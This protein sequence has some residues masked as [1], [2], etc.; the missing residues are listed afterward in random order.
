MLLTRIQCAKRLLEVGTLAGFSTL[1]LA[2]GLPDDGHITACEFLPGHAAVAQ[3]TPMPLAMPA[4]WTSRSAQ[5][6][7]LNT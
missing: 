6:T 3:Q 5:A 7:T 4:Q 1:W 2:R